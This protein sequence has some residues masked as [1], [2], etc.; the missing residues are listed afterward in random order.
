MEKIR[1]IYDDCDKSLS[2]MIKPLKDA[3]LNLSKEKNTSLQSY[4]QQSMAF[5]DLVKNW[6][7]C[8]GLAKLIM[9]C[10]ELYLE[11]E[12]E[13]LMSD[14]QGYMNQYQKCKGRIFIIIGSLKEC[15]DISSQLDEYMDKCDS[16]S[17]VG[18]LMTNIVGEMDLLEEEKSKEDDNWDSD[19][20][21]STLNTSRKQASDIKEDDLSASDKESDSE[22]LESKE[23]MGLDNDE[24]SEKDLLGDE[25]LTEAKKGGINELSNI[26]IIS[27]NEHI[28][29]GE[30]YKFN[31][32]ELILQIKNSASREEQ[33]EHA[34]FKNEEA[35]DKF[36]EK[37]DI[38]EFVNQLIKQNEIDELYMKSLNSLLER[39]N[40]Y[41]SRMG[42]A[43]A[44][45]MKRYKK[46]I[47][48]I[49]DCIKNP[50]QIL[51]VDDSLYHMT[52]CFC[53][54]KFENNKFNSQIKLME[55]VKPILKEL[56]SILKK[57]NTSRNFRDF[58]IQPFDLD[59]F[60][61]TA[62][63]PENRD[64]NLRELVQLRRRW[65]KPMTELEVYF[66]HLSE[67]IDS[68]WIVYDDNKLSPECAKYRIYL[69]NKN[70]KWSKS[71]KTTLTKIV[72][73]YHIS[74]YDSMKK[75]V[76]LTA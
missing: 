12:S 38:L 15:A 60:V 7:E 13:K 5:V 10:Y 30:K 27:G 48:S 4:H 23:S 21:I 61:S 37:L 76:E 32:R 47:K 70:T 53:A 66:G 22:S 36:I 54:V 17:N 67:Y 51:E 52:K 8:N 46:L 62:K 43:N 9:K 45:I 24:I 14:I 31:T 28:V 68:L 33:I 39:V 65:L 74:D 64:D 40:T 25:L 44:S 59:V 29:I 75:F 18:K 58:D 50:F 56:V 71:D 2:S 57:K 69:L 1:N 16:L 63:I 19:K 6:Q 55:S 49:D 73:Q 26:T 41:C 35:L 34:G 11:S 72:D 3:L 20:D 42:T